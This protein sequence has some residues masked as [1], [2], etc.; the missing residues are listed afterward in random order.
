MTKFINYYNLCPIPE[1]KDFLGIA[2]DR[3][4]GNI[5]TT[6]SKNI[7]IIMKISTRKQIRSWSILE[8]LSSKVVYDR[9]S[10]K[11][12]GVFANKIL[13]CWDENTVDVNKSKKLR[14]HK[15]ITELITNAEDTFVLYDDGSC[16]TLCTA[17]ET[18]KEV[19]SVPHH[20]LFI[21]KLN[22]HGGR[23][24]TLPNGK[25]IVTYFEVNALTGEC[26]LIRLP[27]ENEDRTQRYPL[28]RGNLRTTVSGATVI[29][30]DGVP[31]L[32]TIWSDKRIFLLSL[33]D[34]VPPERSPGTFVS[35]LTHL[36]VDSPLSLLGVSGY[37]VAIYGANYGQ[38]KERE[39]ASLLL[40]NIQ[41]KVVK[42]NQFFKVY[43]DFSKLWSVENH[44]LL[45][46]GQNLSVVQYRVSKEVL[47]ELVGT[48]ICNDYQNP[49][50]G[51]Q[52]NEEDCIQDYLQYTTDI[53]RCL[54]I[55]I[56]LHEER[57]RIIEANGKT[58]PFIGINAFEKELNH[59]K[60]MNLYVDVLETNEISSNEQITLMNN[61]NDKGFTCPEI[62]ILA[63]QMEKAGASEH[64]ITEKLLWLLIKANLLS[65]IG[66]CLKRYTNISEKML[67]KTLHFILKQIAVV[68][69]VAKDFSGNE[70]RILNGRVNSIMDIDDDLEKECNEDKKFE[71]R[72]NFPNIDLLVK[73][74]S[75][76]NIPTGS[77][78]I[79]N[80]LL[81]CNFDFT[82]IANYI[83]QDIKYYDVLMLLEYLYDMLADP[84]IV[85]FEERPS[86]EYV[87]TGFELKILRWFGVFINTHFQKL[88]LS[89]DDQLIEMLLRWQKLFVQYKREIVELQ[90]T[91]A[92]LY[93]IVEHKKLT[94]DRDYSKWYS[95]EQ[96]HLF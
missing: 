43:F 59:L 50:E 27:L 11:Y 1:P 57:T 18:R 5:I 82:A 67:S 56:P 46:L 17:I 92:L 88:A 80:I 77:K 36:K 35:M 38:K 70:A 16:E 55:D 19:T 96:I 7:V 13:R 37:S 52:I 48:Q 51:D 21:S 72:T 90:E 47:S 30:G 10:E 40:Y 78:D 34:D 86:H 33:D 12:V 66:V 49:V 31:L 8:K 69:H 62:Q 83:R 71:K 60:H 29:E 25:Q 9:R 41:Y 24:F 74:H 75:Q 87:S 53:G 6:L 79:L 95:I 45:A 58:V 64:E 94:K 76:E 54:E 73:K 84:D 14:F 4:E 3:E 15:N 81:S 22:L 20:L 68:D 23:I 39:G 26:H 28:K 93:N 32:C 42:V 91:A 85:S 2:A 44:I 89:K 61:Y 65:D 63:S